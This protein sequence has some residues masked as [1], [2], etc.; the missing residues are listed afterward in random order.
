MIT[1]EQIKA[2]SQKYSINESI[3]AREFVQIS[4]LKELYEDKISNGIFFKG[5]TAIRLLYGGKRFSE[6]LDFT[7]QIEEPIFIEHISK[8]FNKLENQY[9]F[10]FK[11]R[12]TITGKTYL[13]TATQPFLKSEVFVKLDFSIRE[14]V[15]QPTKSILETEYP[16]I[17][18]SFVHSLSKD[19]ILAEKI[20]AVLKREK[21]R[22]L[23][24]LWILQELGAKVDVELI[25]E[26][27]KY[28]CEKFDS[29]VL[30]KRLG[31]FSKEEFIK[32]LRPFVPIHERE[33]LGELFE[34]VLVYLERGFSAI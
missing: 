14:N 13:L 2:L 27:M 32:D 11:E 15:L 23:Y 21:H 3:V 26:K 31:I 18:Q 6:D 10:S 12:K 7:V 19:E 20:R 25:K 29:D 28:Y 34:Y 17:V 9:P 22:D 33:K 8:L 1:K 4:F 24:D 30:M 5:G 16:V